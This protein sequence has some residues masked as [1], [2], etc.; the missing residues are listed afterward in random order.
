MNVLLAGAEGMSFRT[1][2]WVTA[3]SLLK[4]SI[5]TSLGAGLRNFS[6]QS[7]G[8]DDEDNLLGKAYTVVGLVMCVVIFVYLTYVVRKQVD[9]ELED[10]RRYGDDEERMAFLSADGEEM[11]EVR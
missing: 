6:S 5:H 9:G 8:E 3:L 1:Y 7:H 10:E 2:G 11:E 4:I